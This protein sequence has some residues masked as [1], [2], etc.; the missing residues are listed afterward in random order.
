MIHKFKNKN[1]GFFRAILLTMFCF[2]TLTAQNTDRQNVSLDALIQEALQNNPM[3]QSMDQRVRA[4]EQRAPQVSALDDPMLSYTRWISSVET[5]VGPQEN[6]LMLSQ[7]LPFFGKLGLRGDMAEQDAAATQQAYS[8]TRRDIVFRVK[9]AFYDLYWIDQSLA[10]LDEY[11]RLLQSFQ[12]VAARK[13]ATGTG[14]QANVLKAQ[15]EISSIDERRLNFSKMR[16]GAVARLNALLGREQAVAIGAVSIVDTALYAKAEQELLQSAYTA[17]QELLAAE[18]MVAKADLGIKLARKN[19][20]PDLSLAATYITIPS[21]RT[22]APDNGKDPWSIQ[23]GINLPIW[24]GKRRAAVD[25]AQA[26]RVAN[27]LHQENLRNE[28]AAEI[29][30][31]FARLKTGEQTLRLYREQLLPD[32]ERTLQSSQSSYQTGTLDFLSLLDSERML[33]QFRLAYVK[34]LANYRQQ[35]AAL[36]RTVGS[37]R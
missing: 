11:Q 27:Q 17:R 9:H 8:A 30:D 10:I 15:V 20:W 35:V 34:E 13:Y 29:R 14:I 12:Q 26:T 5:R 23:A 36:E 19:Y 37:E 6:V 7:R 3:I 2:G 4:A 33:L 22:M 1:R 28:I 21:G 25:E 24:L 18:A 32:A 16:E 31:L